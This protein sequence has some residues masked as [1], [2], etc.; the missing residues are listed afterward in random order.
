MATSPRTS[1]HR[2]VSRRK[3]WSCFA[4]TR[5]ADLEAVAANKHAQR[6]VVL[7][8]KVRAFNKHPPLPCREPEHVAGPA[9]IG[10]ANLH[11]LGIVQ[12]VEPLE[13]FGHAHCALT[14]ASQR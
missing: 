2:E 4:P 3:G 13:P 7:R 14:C 6:A 1:Q 8:H 9:G 5:I 12:V 11:L 10:T